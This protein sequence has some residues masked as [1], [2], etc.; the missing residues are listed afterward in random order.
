MNPLFQFSINLGSGSREVI[1]SIYPVGDFQS[2]PGFFV[3]AHRGASYYAPENTLPA[4]ELAIE[5]KSDMIELDVTLTKDRIPIVFHDKKLHRTT[6]GKGLVKNFYL[7]ELRE[8]NAGSWF[9]PSYKDVKIPSLREVLEWAKNKISLNIEI[10]KEALDPKAES[11]GV[12]EMVSELINEFDM[13]NQVVVSSFSKRVVR[14]LSKLDTP[15]H[16]SFLLN[17]Y[18]MDTRRILKTLRSTGA[19]GLNLGPHQM[20]NS[21]MRNLIQRKIPVWVYTIDNELQMR[22]VSRKGATGIFTNRPDLLHQVIT[23]EAD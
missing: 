20:R 17:Q 23:R 22:E 18:E 21:L 14:Q 16:R 10:K 19:H 7:R 13:Q 3:I 15:I 11:G 5:L 8:L 6:T 12:A 4:F 9:D 1:N 2:A